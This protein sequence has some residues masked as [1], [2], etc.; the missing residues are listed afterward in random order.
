M[1]RASAHLVTT[2]ILASVANNAKMTA[3]ETASATMVNANAILHGTGTIAL[4]LCV[5]RVKFLILRTRTPQ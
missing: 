3:Q 2:A 4:Y 5:A 1:V